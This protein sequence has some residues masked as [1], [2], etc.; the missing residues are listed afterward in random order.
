MTFDRAAFIKAN[1]HLAAVPLCP[2]IKL[3]LADE[4][5]ALWQK[6]E[7]ELHALDLPPPY[8]AFAWAGGQAL[9]RYILDNPY[10]VAGKRV[11]D[12]AAGS[13]L[14]AIAAVKAGAAYVEANDIDAFAIEAIGLN[15]AVNGADVRAMAG[16]IIG[17][18]SNWNV[19]LAGDVSYQRDMAEPISDW[20][21]HLA[22]TG[23]Q[24][25]IG[26]PG[27]A[28]LPRDKLQ[29]LARYEVPVPKSLE[30]REIKL[31]EVWSFKDAMD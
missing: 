14:I 22:S 24:V 30:D 6:T 16:N 15:A 20:L 8:W 18:A 4:A 29:S 2:D 31:T 7:D 27:R 5:T 26:D 21:R 23:T 17:C 11:L 13:G 12:L 19:V 10:L 28:Y 1:T 9:A 3:Y 25:L